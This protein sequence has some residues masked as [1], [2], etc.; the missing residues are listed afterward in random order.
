MVVTALAFAVCNP[1]DAARLADF[2]LKLFPFDS[3]AFQARAGRRAAFARGVSALH[4]AASGLTRGVLSNGEE[5]Q[6]QQA[7]QTVYQD[8]ATTT[9]T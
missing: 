9:L 7:T 8:R 5:E 1:R 6:K 4:A 3:R 2:S